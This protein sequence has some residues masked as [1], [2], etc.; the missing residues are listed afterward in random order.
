MLLGVSMVT[1]LAVVVRFLFDGTVAALL[2]AIT[3]TAMVGLWIGVPRLVRHHQA[4]YDDEPE[5]A[6]AR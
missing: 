1:S 5:R 3:V 6:T 2:V 4:R